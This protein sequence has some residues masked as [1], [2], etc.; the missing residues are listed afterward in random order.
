MSHFFYLVF[1]FCWTSLWFPL[2]ASQVEAAERSGQGRQWA[3]RSGQAQPSFLQRGAIWPETLQS[4]Q[5]WNDSHVFSSTL[6]AFTSWVF[7]C[8]DK[9]RWKFQ[10]QIKLDLSLSFFPLFSGYGQWLCWWWRWDVQRVWP[11][12]PQWQRYGL[13][14]L[15]AQQEYRQRCLHRWFGL[16]HAQQQVWGLL[17]SFSFLFSSDSVIWPVHLFNCSGKKMITKMFL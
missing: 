12:F 15:Q 3:H 13:Q 17:L 5:G 14:H 4:E 1:D 9:C 7:C 10:F 2:S 8:E 16:T 11:A 6:P